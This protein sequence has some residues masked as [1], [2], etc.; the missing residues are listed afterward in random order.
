MPDVIHFASVAVTTILFYLLFEFDWFISYLVGLVVW[1]AIFAVVFSGIFGIPRA[2]FPQFV[3][4]YLII[5]NAM[6][7][8]LSLLFGLGASSE[9]SSFS[10]FRG[11]RY[12][13]LDLKGAPPTVDYLKKVFPLF[14][15][16][17]ATG[18]LI[19]WEDTLPYYDDLSVLRGKIH[20]TEDE[21]KQILHA[22]QSSGL[23]VIPLVQ[24]FG[25][26]EFVLKHEKFQHL[27]EQPDKPDA[28]CPSNDES[29]KLVL[30]LL[31]QFLSFHPGIK[32]I[33]LGGDEVWN[34]GSCSMCSQSSHSDLYMKHMMPLIRF[35]RKNG[36]RALVWD[37]MMRKWPVDQLNKISAYI[38]PVV[39]EYL[40]NVS[41]AYL[42]EGVWD[43]Y[44]YSF[45]RLWAASC[46]KGATGSTQDF[47]AIGYHLSNHIS[48]LGISKQRIP[49]QG[50][51]LTGWTRYNHIKPLCEILPEGIPS[52]AL[53]LGVLQQEDYTSAIQKNTLNVI[54]LADLPVTPYNTSGKTKDKTYVTPED[55][56]EL[57][58]YASQYLGDFPGAEAYQ[59]IAK[60]ELEKRSYDRI[61][62]EG[63]A[64]QYDFNKVF[65]L[66][67]K[68][69]KD[70]KGI[71]Y[72][73]SIE[74]LVQ[75]QQDY[76]TSL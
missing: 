18:L 41:A 68:L 3:T 7:F 46:Y 44:S 58:E 62:K 52:L 29:L 37:D 9:G 72:E 76:F 32:A 48:W 66:A 71:L 42:P 75:K 60:F 1:S 51:I 74:E 34:I 16:L 13:H 55:T 5:A 70:L 31:E 20:Y 40:P 6:F 73:D 45:S 36:L 69:K 56:K 11:Q 33:H 35:V 26:L 21:V 49:F 27:R 61:K 25:H 22:A 4:R 57:L 14:K 17:G 63:K 38:E 28:L 39:W 64:R 43:R 65:S 2:V 12:V 67:D 54:G 50:I 30:K 24:T 8:G 10:S 19:E 47:T 53:N 59:T 15:K 23:S